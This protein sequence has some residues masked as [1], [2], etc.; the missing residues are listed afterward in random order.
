MIIFA[1]IIQIRSVSDRQ[2]WGV[3]LLAGRS[4]ADG[5][6][7]AHLL[8]RQ[9]LLF[10]FFYFRRTIFSSTSYWINSTLHQFSFY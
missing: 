8:Y 2:S 6:A 4:A 7:A 9:N 3:D 1:Y 5:S 10:G